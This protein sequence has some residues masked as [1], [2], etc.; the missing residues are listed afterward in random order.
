MWK[1]GKPEIR[2]PGNP[3]TPET[4]G[5]TERFP[6]WETRDSTERFSDLFKKTGERSVCPRVY[7][8]PFCLA[9][10]AASVRLDAPSLLIASER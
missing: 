3:E 6:I 2:K 9:M 7:S 5:Q 8:Q 1:P 10:R 4:R